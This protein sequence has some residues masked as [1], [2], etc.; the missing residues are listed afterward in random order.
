MGYSFDEIVVDEL[1]NPSPLVNNIVYLYENGTTKCAETRTDDDGKFEFVLNPEDIL[2]EGYGDLYIQ[3]FPDNEATYVAGYF[4]RYRYTSPLINNVAINQ[5]YVCDIN[6]ATTDTR[7]KA[8]EVS[9]MMIYPYRYVKEMSGDTLDKIPTLYPNGFGNSFCLGFLLAIQENSYDKWDIGMHEYGHYINYY[10][11]ACPIVFGK[12]NANQD[13]T[14]KYG[15]SYGLKLAYSEALATYIGMSSQYKYQLYNEDIFTI[16]QYNYPYTF[17]DGT[18]TYIDEKNMGEVNEIGIY[19]FLLMLNEGFKVD[20]T[21]IPGI[22]S[23]DAAKLNDLQN[24]DYEIGYQNLFDVIYSKK[25][26]NFSELISDLV[27]SFPNKKDDMGYLLEYFGFSPYDIIYFNLLFGE[28]ANHLQLTSGQNLFEWNNYVY[29]VTNLL[30]RF[31]IKFYSD[32]ANQTYTIENITN[33]YY[34]LTDA[35]LNEL[36]AFDTYYIRYQIIGYHTNSFTTGPYFSG[37][38]R[39][40]LPII[41]NLN[42]TS[43]INE[44]Y[45]SEMF[46][47]SAPIDGVYEFKTIGNLDTYGELFNKMV[48]NTS[49]SGLIEQ[50]YGDNSENET[51]LNFRFTYYLEK[52]QTVYLRVT[53]NNDDLIGYYTPVVTCIEHTH[54]FVYTSISSTHHILKCHCGETSGIAS[55]HCVDSSASQGLNKRCMYCGVLID[56]TKPGFFPV[57]GTNKIKE[58][59]MILEE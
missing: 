24:Y 54:N 11:D 33:Y 10:F 39:L 8:Y 9:Q 32:T 7:S 4:T 52:N 20:T 26:N 49:S 56:S 2:T 44:Y 50:A 22:T 25:R 3:I 18:V 28:E 51:N 46:K 34:Y 43:S 59:D 12:H 45:Q 5:S 41:E 15:K 57:I 30:D 40:E 13:L 6:I 53:L 37:L 23:Y 58:E 38:Y 31:D 21:L 16:E 55:I 29:N 1:L 47:F 35:D 19:N 14:D 42:S 48:A 36:L 27:I 17:S